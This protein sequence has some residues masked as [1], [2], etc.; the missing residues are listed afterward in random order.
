MHQLEELR[1]ELGDDAVAHLR[2]RVARVAQWLDHL[3][4]E[5]G[6]V[7]EYC[8]RRVLEECRLQRGDQRRADAAVQLRLGAIG[9]ER[10]RVREVLV[11]GR[12]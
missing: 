7:D 11:E 5:G 3:A 12:L 8:L 6:H 1:S 10:V 4:R 9:D 2:A